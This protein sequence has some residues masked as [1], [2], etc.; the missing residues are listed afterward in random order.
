MKN[1][2][3]NIAMPALLTLAMFAAPI[4]AHAQAAADQTSTAAPAAKSHAQKRQDMVEQRIAELHTQLA[5]T[6]QQSKQW[7]AFAQTM[8]DNAQKTSQAFK[9]RAQK[10]ATMNADDAM[11]SYSDLAQLHAQNMQKLSSAMSDLYASLSDEQKQTADSLYRH[12][13]GKGHHGMKK[14][15]AGT[16]AAPASQP[17]A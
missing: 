1:S 8:R 10:L 6:D 3:R 11:K 7:D 14:H 17:G 2:V 4:W 16:P 15:K 12:E 9:D 5:I 13:P